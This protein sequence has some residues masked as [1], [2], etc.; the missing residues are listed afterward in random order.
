MREEKLMDAMEY[1]DDELLE[2]A[3]DSMEG[4]KKGVP[5]AQLAAIAACVGLVMGGLLHFRIKD[6][7]LGDDPIVMGDSTVMT[8]PPDTSNPPLVT[9][10]PSVTDPPPVTVPPEVTDPLRIMA[11]EYENA[12]LSAEQIGDLFSGTYGGTKVY[13]KVGF[14]N[15]ALFTAPEIPDAKNINVYQWTYDVKPSEAELRTVLEDVFPVIEEMCGIDIP[16]PTIE[17]TEYA[18]TALTIIEGKRIYAAS[19]AADTYVNWEND[20]NT[21]LEI[22][23]EMLYAKNTQ[24]DE[25]IMQ[26]LSAVIPYLEHIFGMDLSAYKIM[27]DYSSAG[28]AI[29]GM[30]IYLYSANQIH[31]EMLKQYDEY[32]PRYCGG[33]MLCL[34]YSI[35]DNGLGS[36]TVVCREMKYSKQQQPWYEVYAK[37]RMLSLDEAE[38]LLKQGCVFSTHNCPLCMAQQAEVDFSDYDH[39]SLEYVF[40]DY[41]VPFYTFYKKIEESADGSVQYAKTMVPAIEVSGLEEYFAEQQKYHRSW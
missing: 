35:L 27:R 13:E 24:T 31:D 26:S 37:C 23:G 14:P 39:V 25:E 28:S 9:V 5:W 22:N 36:D 41:G 8:D 16:M 17:H 4:E 3:A 38:Y 1:V 2:S 40:D 10:P 30:K 20:N 12:L 6:P 18:Y 15:E 33:D 32:P 7:T 29:Y 19:R 11:P 21:P 34:N